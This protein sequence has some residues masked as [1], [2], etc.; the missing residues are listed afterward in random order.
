MPKFKDQEAGNISMNSYFYLKYL[1]FLHNIDLF[2]EK[3]PFF[4]IT[5]GNYRLWNK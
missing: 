4:N 3:A 2:Y 5:C 1:L